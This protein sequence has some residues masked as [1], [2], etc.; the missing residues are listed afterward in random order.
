MHRLDDKLQ[1]ATHTPYQFLMYVL[2]LQKPYFLSGSTA[3]INYV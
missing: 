2:E 1:K 3:S